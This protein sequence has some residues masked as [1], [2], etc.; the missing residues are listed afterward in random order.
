MSSIDVDFAS[1]V[2]GERIGR[3]QGE[4]DHERR[5]AGFQAHRNVL[6]GD[7]GAPPGRT[8]SKLRS[9]QYSRMRFGLD[10]SAWGWPQPAALQS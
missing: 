6:L 9:L 4:N 8:G 10:V 1:A 3:A 2:L 5:C 7:L